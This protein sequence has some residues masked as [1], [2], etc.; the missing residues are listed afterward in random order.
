MYRW[1]T[2]YSPVTVKHIDNQAETGT[3]IGTHAD[4][5]PKKNGRTERPIEQLFEERGVTD[6]T[7]NTQLSIS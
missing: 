7:L 2:G 5:Q 4:T 3:N 1:S 6:N